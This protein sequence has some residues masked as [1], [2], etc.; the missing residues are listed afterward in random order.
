MAWTFHRRADLV[1]YLRA[2][3]AGL[4]TGGVLVLN[5][6]GGSGA[7]RALVERTRKRGS[8]AP[9]GTWVKPFTYVWEQASFNAIDSR[10]LAWI[11]FEPRQGPRMLRAFTYDWRMWTLPELRDAVLEAGFR[12]FG[13]WSEGWHSKRRTHTGALVKR[14]NLENDDCWIAY[15][16]AFR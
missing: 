15:C 7:E 10:L 1:A 5:A 12:D 13:V 6:L 11:H 3:R 8:S 16:A 2:A 9:D 4:R 14:M